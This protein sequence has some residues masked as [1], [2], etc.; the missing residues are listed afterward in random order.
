MGLNVHYKIL[1]TTTTTTIVQTF[2]EKTLFLLFGGCDSVV[3]FITNCD[4]A[5]YDNKW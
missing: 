5:P 3:I 4:Q 1:T 2:F